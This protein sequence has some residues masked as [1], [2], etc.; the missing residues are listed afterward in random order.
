MAKKMEEIGLQTQIMP[1]DG[2]KR[3]NSIC[4]WRRNNKPD[5]GRSPAKP[6]VFNGHVDMNPVNEG[7]TH[8]RE[9]STRTSSMVLVYL[10]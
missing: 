7:W 1:F 5:D 2:D 8:G 4:I 3:Q 10:T 9:R 6:L